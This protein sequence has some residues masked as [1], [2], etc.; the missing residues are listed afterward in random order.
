VG[1]AHHLMSRG[2][3]VTAIIVDPNSFDEA[4]R[5]AVDVDIELTASHIPYFIVCEGDQPEQALANTR[6]KNKFQPA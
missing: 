6:S 2:V 3:R 5:N 4:Y 1:A